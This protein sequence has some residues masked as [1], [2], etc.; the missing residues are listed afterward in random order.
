LA[1]LHQG[2]RRRG[3]GGFT[4][5]GV[6]RRKIEQHDEVRAWRRRAPGAH[7]GVGTGIPKR[8]QK[9]L[10][11]LFARLL[12]HEHDR[13]CGILLVEH[14]TKSR[15]ASLRGDGDVLDR[16]RFAGFPRG[17]HYA[18]RAAR[19]TL[20][21]RFY[22]RRER[23]GDDNPGGVLGHLGHQELERRIL[24]TCEELIGP[25][26]AH[27]ANRIQLEGRRAHQF[28]QRARTSSEHLGRSQLEQPGGAWGR[29][30]G[31]DLDV[32]RF[33]EANRR[34]A[35]SRRDLRIRSHDEELRAAPP[36]R[37]VDARD[38]RLEELRDRR[39]VVRHL[40]DDVL[41]S[42]DFQAHISR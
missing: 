22:R 39:P 24:A 31:D 35:Y 29:S 25:R 41:P 28:E 7:A 19:V 32:G 14:A 17:R 21:Q 36:L 1:R 9:R 33:D 30:R 4:Q 27:G 40:I 18:S 23:C 8:A 10:Y 5:L 6:R 26:D 20:D 11:L 38:Q 42:C 3:A 34:G 37:R 12:A 2:D 13:R 16:R 15:Q